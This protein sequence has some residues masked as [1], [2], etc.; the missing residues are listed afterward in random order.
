M[1]LIRAT[2][3]RTLP[4][5]YIKLRHTLTLWLAL[6]APLMVVT[7][8]V[9][10]IVM[11][12]KLPAAV[13]GAASEA[14]QRHLMGITYLWTG[15]MLPLMIALQAAWL[16]AL[17]HNGAQ[18]KQLLA[19]PVPRSAHYLAK[20]LVL[21]GLLLLS[22]LILVLLMPLS[23][24]LMAWLR[25]AITTHGAPPWRFIARIGVQ[26][27]LACGLMVVI[28]FWAALRWRSFTAAIG[29]GMAGTVASFL[30]M[31]SKYGLWFPWSMPTQVLVNR[32]GIAAQVSWLGAGGLLVLGTLALMQLA[33]REID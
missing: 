24:W 21:L 4:A 18:W 32:P 14:W 13:T 1:N 16:A 30:I 28:Q 27:L 12:Q 11:R 9:L 2:L 33:R 25:P 17:E 8:C 3:T 5:E 31:Q 20:L 29:L 19:Q 10:A 26:S 6:L 22:Q 7:L 23:G 15:M